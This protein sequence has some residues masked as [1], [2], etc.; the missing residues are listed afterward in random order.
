MLDK[1]LA[2][3]YARALYGVAKKQGTI[4][5]VIEEVES[6]IKVLEVDSQLGKFFL[7]PAISPSEKKQMLKELVENR[8]SPLSLTF[9]SILFDAK[10]TNYVGLI[11][12]TVAELY[13][14]DRNRTRAQFFSVFPID[15]ALRQKIE[16]RVAVYLQK[17]VDLEFLIDPDI[18]G[19]VK[20]KISDNVIDATALYKLKKIEEKISLG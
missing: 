15:P 4:V 7:H 20:L 1:S 6:F 12:G 16:E 11:C 8:I 5:A 9:L 2:Y 19:G 10:R 18:L 3:R 14:K 17:E 13:D